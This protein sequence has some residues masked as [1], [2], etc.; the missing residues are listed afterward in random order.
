MGL[1]GEHGS[2]ARIGELAVTSVR[3][4]GISAIGQLI[5]NENSVSA[6]TLGERRA[7]LLQAS[8]LMATRSIWGVKMGHLKVVDATRPF[9][10]KDTYQPVQIPSPRLIRVSSE[11]N[12]ALRQVAHFRSQPKHLKEIRIPHSVSVS[13]EARVPAEEKEKQASKKSKPLTW[14]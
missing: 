13:A 7:P 6:N 5:T 4:A 14:G 2:D 12:I 1:W 3:R 10:C 9:Q 8:K 11:V